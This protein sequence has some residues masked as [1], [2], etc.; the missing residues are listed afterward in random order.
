MTIN[1]IDAKRDANEREI[2]EFLDTL[3]VLWF[4][5]SSTKIPDLLVCHRG[6]WILLEVKAKQG[7]LTDH[8]K[9]F[10]NQVRAQVPMPPTYVVRDILDVEMALGMNS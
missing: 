4:P 9:D 5:I 7:R 2:T 10:F 3:G 1:R 8:Q 6:A